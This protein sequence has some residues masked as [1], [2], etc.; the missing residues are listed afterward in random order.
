MRTERPPLTPLATAS[1]RKLQ[2]AEQSL[3][4]AKHHFMAAFAGHISRPAQSEDERQRLLEILESQT[5]AS[6]PFTDMLGDMRG[7][8]VRNGRA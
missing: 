3:F 7:W 8:L 1:L 2:A 4:E 6:K 5:A